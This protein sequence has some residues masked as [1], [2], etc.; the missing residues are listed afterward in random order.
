MAYSRIAHILTCG[1]Y[2]CD[3]VVVRGM[4]IGID[5][6]GDRLNHIMIMDVYVA[7]KTSSVQTSNYG[8]GA[9]RILI[10]IL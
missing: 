4:G 9:R 8:H 6:A 3:V 2:P 1:E 7:V 10:K 5:P